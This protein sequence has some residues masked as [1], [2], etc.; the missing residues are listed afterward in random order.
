[1]GNTARIAQLKQFIKADKNDP[2]P[3]YALALEFIEK[4]PN[5][6]LKL[7]KEL[8]NNHAEYVATYYHAANL[9]EEMGL[10]KEARIT[11]ENGMEMARKLND[12]HA[13]KELKSA[14]LNFQFEHDI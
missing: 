6:S 11:Y 7:F 1:M 3:K 9:Y 4:E 2:F 10:L 8:L 13:L 5:E 12:L 14:Y